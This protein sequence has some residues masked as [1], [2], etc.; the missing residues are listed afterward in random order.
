MREEKE[1]EVIL[2][3]VRCDFQEI[4]G[5]LNGND[6]GSNSEI[7][8]HMLDKPFQYEQGLV[9]AIQFLAEDSMA[10]ANLLNKFFIKTRYVHP[11]WYWGPIEAFFRN[12]P[13]LA[14]SLSHKMLQLDTSDGLSSGM[15]LT[16]ILPINEE[17]FRYVIDNLNS[18][19]EKTRRCSAIAIGS[20]LF[21]KDFPGKDELLDGLAKGA[22]ATTQLLPELFIALQRAYEHNP[23]VF[24][25]VICQLIERFG[26]E[27]AREYIRASNDK[28]NVSINSLKMAVETLERNGGD[29]QT[30]DRG[31]ATIYRLDKGFVVE[32]LRTRLLAQESLYDNNS[33]LTFLVTEEDP[34]PVIKMIME[35]VGKGNRLLDF[36]AVN[37]LDDL[38]KEN[39]TTWVDL[40]R[41][42]VADESKEYVVLLSIGM[43]L[44]EMVHQ[45]PYGMSKEKGICIS[46]VRDISQRHA[47]DFSKATSHINLGIS[48]IPGNENKEEALRALSMVNKMRFLEETIDL[49]T[50]EENLKRAPSI[51]KLVGGL[52]V[53]RKSARTE[54]PHV[55]CYIFDG[56]R[57]VIGELE[58]LETKIHSIEDTN[59]QLGISLIH[60]RL[61]NNQLSQD[62]W[63]R[64]AKK[65]TE[66]KMTVK[67]SK[68]LDADNAVNILS[69]IE[70]FA[71]L[72]GTFD[73]RRDVEVEGFGRKKLEGSIRLE[74]EESLI[75]VATVHGALEN[76]L[77]VGPYT[78]AA[79][80]VGKILSS[81]LDYQFCRGTVDPKRPLIVVLCCPRFLFSHRRLKFTLTE[82][83]GGSG[84]GVEQT[85]E[86]MAVM[87]FFSDEAARIVSSVVIY[88]GDHTK[89]HPLAGIVV[90]NPNSPLHLPSEKFTR[91]LKETLFGNS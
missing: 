82:A 1:I 80:K 73:I 39:R 53:L 12:D 20:V 40:C 37:D 59:E 71:H 18:Q 85:E 89:M 66:A 70:V 35:E 56:R 43:L 21:E 52:D 26:V 74:D 10:Y 90:A 13:N 57:P 44:G 8:E 67:R 28:S 42:W 38:L 6:W 64:M 49:A 41:E 15:L 86:E 47:V 58:A 3:G 36:M 25:K 27:A 72:S 34:A 45:D 81:K 61:L 11:R 24:E 75:E 69:E 65:Y 60:D 32:R 78:P 22:L 51:L 9:E 50:L 33:H 63:E 79:T 54:K 46:M 14:C 30:I 62:Y 68:L 4:R 83:D 55:L 2:R 7:V 76:E 87:E 91:R 19:D 31:L 17:G 23:T 84:L 77:A 5:I 88:Y 16:W 48:K 29:G